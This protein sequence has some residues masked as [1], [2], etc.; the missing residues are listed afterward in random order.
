MFTVL[1][2][3]ITLFKMAGASNVVPIDCTVLTVIEWF[4]KDDSLP[5]FVF[6]TFVGFFV[7]GA[8]LA[9]LVVRCAAREVEVK[10][11]SENTFTPANGRDVWVFHNKAYIALT[12][13]LLCFSLVVLLVVLLWFAT[14]EAD[15][16]KRSEKR[17]AEGFSSSL[18]GWLVLAGAVILPLFGYLVLKCIFFPGKLLLFRQYYKVNL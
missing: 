15:E 5:G 8:M 2:H 4:P 12:L 9:L 18:W 7:L 14:R 6:L 3:K 11:R 10:R 16:R 13:A 17:M 1:D